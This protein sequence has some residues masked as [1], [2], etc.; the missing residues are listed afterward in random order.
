MV[1]VS[2]RAS[3]IRLKAGV[4]GATAN[5]VSG[6]QKLFRLAN[7]SSIASQSRLDLR[8]VAAGTMANFISACIAGM[9]L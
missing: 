2:P 6:V 1:N 8:A 5:F 7:F 3:Q 9:L 4:A